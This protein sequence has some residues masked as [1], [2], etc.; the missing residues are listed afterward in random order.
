[1]KHDAIRSIVV[2]AHYE[3]SIE[4]RQKYFADGVAFPPAR[5]DQL[6]GW[7]DSAGRMPRGEELEL[8]SSGDYRGREA[9]LA[10]AESERDRE[11]QADGFSSIV[12]LAP[13]ARERPLGSR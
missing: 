4:N 11:Q 5:G 6:R 3:P 7:V 9:K 1:M 10:R 8:A 12:A 2:R 13:L